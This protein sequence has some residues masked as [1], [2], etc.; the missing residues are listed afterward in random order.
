MDKPR[1]N[2]YCEVNFSLW[3]DQKGL[4]YLDTILQT[5]FSTQPEQVRTETLK[6]NREKVKNC[7]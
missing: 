4:L 7:S 3:S 2:R 5:Q 6:P 1:S